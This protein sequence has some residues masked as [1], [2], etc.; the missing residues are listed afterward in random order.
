M[1]G[2]IVVMPSDGT[3]SI[4]YTFHYAHHRRGYAF[5]ALNALIDRLH[6]DYPNCDFISFSDPGNEP[7]MTLLNK[8]G[9]INLGYILSKESYAFGKWLTP[10]TEAEISEAV[11]K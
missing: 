2:E 4:G 3:I 10:A 6:N 9:Y 7:S 1:V 8:L 5:E 11:N